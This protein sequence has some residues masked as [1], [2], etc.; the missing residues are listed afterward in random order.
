MT[1]S[2]V[3]AGRDAT[4]AYP[5]VRRVGPAD[6]RDALN[7]GGNDFLTMLDFFAEPLTVV[8]LGIIYPIVCIYL[9]GAGLPLLFPFMSGLTL[10]GPFIAIG[11]YEVSRRRELG[12]DTSWSHVFDLRRSRSL[13][14]IFA[15]GLILLVIFTCWQ[16]AAEIALRM[17]LRPHGD[18]VP[19]GVHHR[20]LHH[21]PGLGL[22]RSGQC[23]WLRLRR[24]CAQHQRRLIPLAPRPQCRRG[25]ECSHVCR[26]RCWLIRPRWRFGD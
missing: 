4:P 10:V 18:E 2:D 17:A 26:E 3:F 6:L 11:L 16:A 21:I 20:G 7:K 1:K 22:D 12:L 24:G 23:N 15:L 14:S 13:P 9:M 25:C 19:W 5:I 8:L